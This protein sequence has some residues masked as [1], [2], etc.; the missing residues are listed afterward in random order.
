MRRQGPDV[1]DAERGD[2]EQRDAARQ[3][4]RDP[5]AQRAASAGARTMRRR[6]SPR[7]AGRGTGRSPTRRDASRSRLLA[8]V[9]RDPRFEVVVAHRRKAAVLL[10]AWPDAARRARR[11][12]CRVRPRFWRART[13][14]AS[15]WAPC[16]RRPERRTPRAARSPRSS[17]T[18]ARCSSGEDAKGWTRSDV[19][20]WCSAGSSWLAAAACW[21]ERSWVAPASGTPSADESDDREAHERDAPPAARRAVGVVPA[22]RED[23][24]AEQQEA[25]GQDR[26]LPEP[27]DAGRDGE[28]GA[29]GGG[30][31]QERGRRSRSGGGR[32]ATPATM[33]RAISASSSV[34]PTSPSSPSVSA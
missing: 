33:I 6:R 28:G 10:S 5:E 27:V 14:G 13:A 29:G 4:G 31:G 7:K 21:L 15:W 17:R 16:A 20:A 9:C 2:R 18:S 12:R 23:G 34:M 1:V 30:A 25:D 8:L 11:P 26:H 22:R 3:V 32:R 24:R 19:L